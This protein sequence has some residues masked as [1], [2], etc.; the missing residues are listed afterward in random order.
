MEINPYDNKA[1]LN[2]CVNAPGGLVFL[3]DRGYDGIEPT[4]LIY[5]EPELKDCAI[6][7]GG[8]QA[9]GAAKIVAFGESFAV[10]LVV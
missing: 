6:T 7:A 9:Q 2:F 1:Q 4:F 10:V 8:N 3:V 5:A